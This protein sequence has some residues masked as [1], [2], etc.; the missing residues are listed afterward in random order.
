MWLVI[1]KGYSLKYG[2]DYGKPFT[3]G[4]TQIHQSTPIYYGTSQ[5]WD[6]IIRSQ[7]SVFK[8]LP[9]Y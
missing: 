8:Q 6:M 4:H 9:W 5:L 2:F 7:A 1:A 3:N